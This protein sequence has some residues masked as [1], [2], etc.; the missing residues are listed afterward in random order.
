MSVIRIRSALGSPSKF[1][2]LHGSTKITFPPASIIMLACRIGV[3]LT[4][5][6]LVLNSSTGR[7]ACAKAT[8]PINKRQ[9]MVLITEIVSSNRTE[10]PKNRRTEEPKNGFS[11]DWN[12]RERKQKNNRRE[13]PKLDSPSIQRRHVENH[14]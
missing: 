12:D 13:N 14:R 3:I 5:P 10:E 11:M 7:E 6:A 9:P 2:W 8:T 1:P 4:T